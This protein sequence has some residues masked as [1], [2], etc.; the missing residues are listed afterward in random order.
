MHT[1]KEKYTRKRRAFQ[2]RTF[3][4]THPDMCVPMSNELVKCFSSVF[5]IQI[6]YHN[7]LAWALVVRA[8]ARENHTQHTH[9]SIHSSNSETHAKCPRADN[10]DN[11]LIVVVVGGGTRAPLSHNNIQAPCFL[12][13][14]ARWPALVMRVGLRLWARVYLCMHIFECVCV[15]SVRLIK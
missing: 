5:S 6:N 7:A 2:A 3:E 12:L 15:C 8:H 13:R 9:T 14:A 1:H 11:A 4:D 10:D